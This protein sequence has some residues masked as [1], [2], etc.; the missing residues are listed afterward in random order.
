MSTHISGHCLCDHVT[1]TYEG[2]V[3]PANL[4][5]CEDCRRCTGSAYNVGVR[6]ETAAFRITRGA[7]KGYT[8]AG[9]SGTLLT[10]WFCPH[11]GSPLYTTSPKHPE[12]LYAKAGTLDDPSVVNVERQCWLDSAVPWRHIDPNLPGFA[13]GFA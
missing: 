12:F 6:L 13:K 2:E 11:F 10:R 1:Y 7:P 4:C 5:H 9:D 3:G 8:K